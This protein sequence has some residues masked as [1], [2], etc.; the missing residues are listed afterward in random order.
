MTMVHEAQEEVEVV[1]QVFLDGLEVAFRSDGT[2]EMSWGYTLAC[3]RCDCLVEDELG[4]IVLTPDRAW[5]LLLALEGC[6]GREEAR[7]ARRAVLRA[8]DGE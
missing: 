1:A 3:P 4:T 5:H 8:L 2:A 6:L 7:E